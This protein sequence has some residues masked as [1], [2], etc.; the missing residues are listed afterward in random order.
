MDGLSWKALQHMLLHYP[1]TP[2][3]IKDFGEIEATL[4][5]RIEQGA[6]L[7]LR[8]SAREA[9]VILDSA[10]RN[11]KF[12]F[13]KYVCR[14]QYWLPPKSSFIVCLGRMTEDYWIIHQTNVS[15][16]IAQ[17]ILF[18][19]YDEIEA[20]WNFCGRDTTSIRN[21]NSRHIF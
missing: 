1:A 14:R 10:P 4:K 16:K 15:L 18:L 9:D 11:T 6:H 19:P 21:L 7:L 8:G 17:S 12:L 2:F 20:G 5:I 13:H 3:G